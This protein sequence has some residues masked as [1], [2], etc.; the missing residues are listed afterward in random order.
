[1]T[2]L[3][4]AL[5]GAAVLPG[6]ILLVLLTKYFRREAIRRGLRPM[7]WFRLPPSMQLAL[8]LFIFDAG[9]TLR[10]GTT[11]FW[12]L[13]GRRLVPMEMMFLLAIL[14]MITGLLCKIRALTE[15]DYGRAPWLISTIVTGILAVLLLFVG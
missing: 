12:Y 9:A 3:L 2:R 8:A 10:L 4:E 11:W 1:M 15:P 5:N 13:I 14:V 7:A 6:L